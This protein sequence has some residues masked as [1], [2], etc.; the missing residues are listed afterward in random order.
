MASELLD[1]LLLIFIV[2]I[3]LIASLLLVIVLN[4]LHIVFGLLLDFIRSLLWW[5]FFADMMIIDKI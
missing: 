2:K 5:S 1:N 4:I 3:L